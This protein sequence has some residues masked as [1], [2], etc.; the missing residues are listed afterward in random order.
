MLSLVRGGATVRTTTVSVESMSDSTESTRSTPEDTGLSGSGGPRPTSSDP[1]PTWAAHSMPMRTKNLRRHGSLVEDGTS[2]ADGASKI[3]SSVEAELAVAAIGASCGADLPSPMAAQ[4][5]VA[6]APD[7]L[8]LM[9][10][11]L[12]TAA[13]LALRHLH[14]GCGS[15]SHAVKV[16]RWHE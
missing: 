3:S 7:A 11:W 2:T 1:G 15:G 14:C 13:A 10:G 4:S 16:V 8:S 9:V 12:M 6:A 5:D